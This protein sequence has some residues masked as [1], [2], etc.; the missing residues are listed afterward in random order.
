MRLDEESEGEI[1]EPASASSQVSA[2]RDPRRR[3]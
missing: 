2:L 3:E 1:R